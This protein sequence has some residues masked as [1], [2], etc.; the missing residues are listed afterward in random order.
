MIKY[1]EKRD[2]DNKKKHIV[3]FDIN[4]IILALRKAFYEVGVQSDTTEE[5]IITLAKRM[6][7][8]LGKLKK[9]TVHVEEIQDIVEKTLIKGNY[10][11][12]AKA[13]ILYREERSKIRNAKTRLMR[14]I[15]EI[16]F[17]EAEEADIKRENANVDGNSAM[18]QMLQYGSATSK[19]FAKSFVLNP[20]HSYAHSNGDIHIH[21]LDFLNMGTLTC[22]TGDTYIT[23]K[24]KKGKIIN[25]T[26]SYLDKLFKNENNL[27]PEIVNIDDYYILGRNGWTLLKNAM[28]RK[29][30][31]QDKLY[32]IKTKKGLGLKSTDKHKIPILRNGEELLL[33][34]EDIKIGDSLLTNP[35]I[36]EIEENE[37][38]NLAEEL[39]K[40]KGKLNKEHIYISN[41]DKLKKWLLY[42]YDIKNL[43]KLIGS[44]TYRNGTKYL[45]LDQLDFIVNNYNIPYEVLITLNIKIK[46]SKNSL[47][48]LLPITN[49]LAKFFGYIY[50]EG[51]IYINEKI[52]VY[53]TTFINHN[54][55]ILNHFDECANSC[56]MPNIIKRYTGEKETGRIIADKLITYLISE[57]IGEKNG[58]NRV[59]IP[60]FIFNATDEIKY[61]FISAI[62]DGDGSITDNINHIARYTTASQKYAEQLVLLLKTLN[63]ESALSK[64][65]IKGTVARFKEVDSVR[66]YDNYTVTITGKHNLAKLLSN[67]NGIKRNQEMLDYAVTGKTVKF[68]PERIIDKLELFE[69]VYVY[70]LETT[71]H[72]FI[73]NNYVVHNCSQIDLNK[74]FT[75]GFSTGHGFLREPNDIISYSALSAIAIQSNQNDQHGGQSISAYDYYLAP[76]VLKTFK[77]KVKDNISK[78]IEVFIGCE[79]VELDELTLEI[80]TKLGDLRSIEFSDEERDRF[81]RICDEVIFDD[82]K[83]SK[84]MVD[85]VLNRS[86]KETEKQTYQAMEAFIH[87]L[88]TMHSRAGAQV[89]F[90]SVNFGTDTSPEGRMVS[91]NL[92]LAQ[93]AGLGKGETAIFPI[94]I[95]KV[96]KGVNLNQEDPNYDLFKLACRV[97]SKRLFPN[98][99]FL[100]ASFNAQYYKEGDI[101]TEVT[102]MGCRTRVIGNICGEEVV[103][104]RGNISFTTINLPR[105]GLMYGVALN[106]RD[107]V[108]LEGF[109]K[110]LDNRIDLVLNQL[111]ER[112]QIQIKKKVKN[113]PFLMGQGIWMGSENL[114]QNDTLEDVVKYG[115]LTIGFI[116][117]AEALK[118]LIGKHHGESEEA[119]KLGLEIIGH[120][121]KRMDEATKKYNLNFALIAT[122]AEGL[123][124]RFTRL[125]KALYGEVEGVTDKD[126]YTNSFH[127]PVY[128]PTSAIKKIKI[129]APYHEFTNGGHISYIEL[130]GDASKNLEAFEAIVRAM[131][132]SGIGYGSINHPVDRDPICGFTGII[133][134]TC[135]SCGREEEGVKFERIRRITGYLVGTVDRFNNAK[136]SEEKDRV[137][138]GV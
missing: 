110:E 50:S 80:I 133:G 118:A 39:L 93:E 70:D 113:F 96:K 4:K 66:N 8:N 123:A 67:L 126:Y 15:S 115:S 136:A 125:D 18:G 31:G 7:R 10:S 129:E 98:F 92:L 56:F 134:D 54:K 81:I 23:L 12:V 71:E 20:S 105:L 128:Y 57:V 2:S 35:H 138:H 32:F 11:E 43:S 76:G 77:K 90:S 99:A 127:V 89:P 29:I 9:E 25:T 87:N 119:Q 19:E 36:V 59:S 6:K 37:Y 60:D 22:L 101:N 88:N 34:A 121:R 21:D 33:K 79:D 86:L 47:P 97:S 49:E 48:I 91:R 85:F 78:Y 30:S 63:I 73:A 46:N 40:S 45:L 51:N 84:K 82:I 38:I 62:I 42:K 102:Y 28:R 75:N 61:S 27:E 109:F 52:G 114:K 1:V 17:S 122:P 55:K 13:Y 124:G 3:D 95:F 24:D 44:E 74:L 120:M 100:D 112:Y 104:G 41:I 111:L 131:A 135:P 72:W 107:K 137:K 94:T 69:D 68:D 83:S 53:H 16:T 5:E 106:E 58:S 108:D 116:G 130:D 132:N 117:L 14:E 103:T 26:I 65:D 64:R